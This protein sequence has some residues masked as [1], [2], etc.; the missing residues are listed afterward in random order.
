MIDITYDVRADANGK[1]PDSHSAT[2]RRYH[3]LLWSKPLPN[4]ADFTLSATRPGTYLHHHSDLGEF[5][6]ASDSVMQTFSRWELTKHLVSQLPEVDITTFQT[7][8]YTIGGMMIFPGNRV[9]A[10][11]TINGARGFTR[12]IADRFDLTLECIRRHYDGQH[13]PLT[14][15]LARY[16][17]FFA[18]FE[19]FPG[20]VDFFLLDDLVTPDGRDIR[21]FM[22]FDDFVFPAVPR[23]VASYMEFRR[24]SMCFMEARNRRILN[25]CEWQRSP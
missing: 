9:D 23:D 17:D 6:L 21:F 18:L 11:M 1:D 10:K 14:D 20:Y 2:L 22:P 4:G 8:G 5:F 7:L 25:W 15:V 19:D 12:R 13:S 16:R 3:K 24:R